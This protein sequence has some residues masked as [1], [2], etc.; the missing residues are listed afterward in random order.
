MLSSESISSSSPSIPSPAS[1]TSSI[2]KV[3]IH[4]CRLTW[5]ITWVI[6]YLKK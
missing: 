4:V 5:N 6:F 2:P 3:N 1:L